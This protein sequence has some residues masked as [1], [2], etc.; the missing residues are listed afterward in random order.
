MNIYIYIYI[1]YLRDE[2]KNSKALSK[3]VMIKNLQSGAASFHISVKSPKKSTSSTLFNEW[4]EDDDRWKSVYKETFYEGVR[5]DDLRR[6][7]RYEQLRY[8]PQGKSYKSYNH[9]K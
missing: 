5:P 9:R 3:N 1:E 4:K 7:V 2:Q 8:P 6:L